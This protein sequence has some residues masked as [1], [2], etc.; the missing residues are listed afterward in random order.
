MDISVD[1]AVN[2]GILKEGDDILDLYL[3][4]EKVNE[5]QYVST[6]G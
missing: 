3:A 4:K 6:V 5:S 1:E 2:N